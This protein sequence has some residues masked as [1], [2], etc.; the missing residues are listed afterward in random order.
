MYNVDLAERI[1]KQLGKNYPKRVQLDELQSGLALAP[2]LAHTE[3]LQSIEV[4]YRQGLIDC[5]HLD[6]SD[7]WD[8]AANLVVTE[9]GRQFVDEDD[10]LDR[11]GDK[12]FRKE[13]D[14]AYGELIGVEIHDL[15]EELSTKGLRHSSVFLHKVTELVVARLDVLRRAIVDSYVRPV[16]QTRRGITEFSENRLRKKLHEVWSQEVIRARGIAIDLCQSTGLAPA[17]VQGPGGQVEARGRKMIFS[18][19]EEIEIAKLRV[20]PA[21]SSSVTVPPQTQVHDYSFI[22]NDALRMAVERDRAELDRL[23]LK[24]ATKSVLVLSGAIIEALLL[25]ALVTAG[26]WDFQEGSRKYLNEMIDLAVREGVIREDRLSHAVRKYRDLV[27]LGREIREQIHFNHDDAVV[28]RGAV[29]VVSGEVQR[30]QL[31][32]AAKAASA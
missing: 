20:E 4:L 1:L 16:Q 22:Q 19:L 25:D 24:F 31:N 11:L 3:W 13:A 7:G 32:R 27:H 21:I 10:R 26:I 8:A 23:D 30:W 29:G 6:G 12:L 15:I 14:N 17:N 5:I 9:S 18:I 28:A 2:N